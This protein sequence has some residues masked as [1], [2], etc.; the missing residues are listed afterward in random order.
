MNKNTGVGNTDKKQAFFYGQTKKCYARMVSRIK[1][2]NAYSCKN[3][4]PNDEEKSSNKYCRKNSFPPL[5]ILHPTFE[6]VQKRN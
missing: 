2:P 5:Y 4:I 6:T 1:T 3:N